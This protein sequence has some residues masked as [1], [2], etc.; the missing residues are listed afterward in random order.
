MKEGSTK[1]QSA[2][3]V[4]ISGGVLIA[5]AIIALYTP[6]L[7]ICDVREVVVSGNQHAATADLVSLSR[8]HRGQTVFSVPTN[9]VRQRLESHPWVKRA[10]VRRIFPHTIQL[11]VEE[12][13]V[14]AWTQHPS[15]NSRVAIAEGGVIVGK[16]EVV[17]SSLEL[18]GAGFSGWE[19]GGSLFN[20]Q[21][22]ELLAALQDDLCQLAVRSVDVTDLRSIEL[23][24]ENDLRVRLGDITRMQDRLT[25]LKA[26][27][28]EIEIDRYELIDVRFGGEATLVPR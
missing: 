5:A 1:R 15:E 28:Q 4:F 20:S 25:A 10:M 6:W 19:I 8:L 2:V 3:W 13:Q 16:D 14:I 21:V 18:V 27:C 9:L 23:F 24:L 12:R 22:A 11:A 17:S 26:L 7:Q